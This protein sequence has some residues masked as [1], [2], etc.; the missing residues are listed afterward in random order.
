MMQS[1]K[2]QMGDLRLID[3]I[4]AKRSRFLTL[5]EPNTLLLHYEVK[6]VLV[7]DSQK[8]YARIELAT[9]ASQR[10]SH[11]SFLLH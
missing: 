3:C 1:Q 11:F 6:H 10:V 8:A 2:Y 7:R 4:G 5:C 9:D